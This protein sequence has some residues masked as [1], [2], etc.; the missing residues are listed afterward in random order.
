MRHCKCPLMNQSVWRRKGEGGRGGSRLI[1][2]NVPL[3][4]C[5]FNLPRT[6][7]DNQEVNHESIKGSLSQ[8]SFQTVEALSQI[9]HLKQLARVR[10][11]SG[12]GNTRKHQL[13]GDLSTCESTHPVTNTC[14]GCAE[15]L[16]LWTSSPTKYMETSRL[17]RWDRPAR[18]SGWK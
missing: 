11:E 18:Y 7:V 8:G 10:L 5:P 12:M 2:A 4:P 14:S 9:S 13:Q 16:R 1:A 3:L 17:A 6:A 15:G